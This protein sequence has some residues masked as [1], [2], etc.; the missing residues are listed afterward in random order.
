MQFRVIFLVLGFRQKFRV[1]LR[2]YKA[3]TG[4]PLETNARFVLD[5]S[6]YMDFWGGPRF[7]TSALLPP[8]H[9]HH[10]LRGCEFF[11]AVLFAIPRLTL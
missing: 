9:H 1:S 11:L 10:A 8:P 2:F 4:S 5:L 3:K 7:R 6:A